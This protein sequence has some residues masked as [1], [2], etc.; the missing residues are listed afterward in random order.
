MCSSDLAVSELIQ[1]I[2]LVDIPAPV[3]MQYFGNETL[4]RSEILGSQGYGG[5]KSKVFAEIQVAL[6]PYFFGNNGGAN[7]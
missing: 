3:W 5:A 6:V 1:A 7:K 4:A 2:N